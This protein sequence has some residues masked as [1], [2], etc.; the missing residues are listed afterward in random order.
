MPACHFSCNS[1]LRCARAFVPCPDDFELRA[2]RRSSRK[3]KRDDRSI[4]QLQQAV[5]YHKRVRKRLEDQLAQHTG[6]KVCGRTG[7]DAEFNLAFIRSCNMF[8]QGQVEAK[9]CV[10]ALIP[11]SNFVCVQ[12]FWG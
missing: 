1:T 2:A 12:R 10:H 9:C 3:R 5:F 6:K 8:Q 11:L 7:D 4:C